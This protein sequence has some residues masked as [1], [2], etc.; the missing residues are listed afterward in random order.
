MQLNLFP[1]VPGARDQDLR[2]LYAG[3][4][5]VPCAWCGGMAAEGS[6]CPRSLPCPTCRRRPGQRCKR[7]SEH[8]AAE[9]HASRWQAAEAIDRA[10]LRGEP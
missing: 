3:R 2:S 8:D 4:R 9:M 5:R 10:V 1:P 7:P 6:I